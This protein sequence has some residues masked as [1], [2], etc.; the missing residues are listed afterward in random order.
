M[1][2]NWITSN[3]HYIFILFCPAIWKRDLRYKSV[4][5]YVAFFNRCVCMK[6]GAW[7][8]RKSVPLSMVPGRVTWDFFRGSF[9]QNHVPWG[10]LS[11]W[12]WVPGIS[13]GVTAAGAFGR[14]PTTFVV[15]NVEMIWG[16]NL[17]GT[18]WATS[19]CRRIPLLTVLGKGMKLHD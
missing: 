5:V 18:P 15:P 17:F 13:P 19:A 1:E 8:W 16:L 7:L 11:L 10:R 3:A 4:H 14:R 2:R 9:R 6:L 12:K